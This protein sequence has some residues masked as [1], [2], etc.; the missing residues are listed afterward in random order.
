MPNV[1]CIEHPFIST[2]GAASMKKM[3]YPLIVGILV[4][5][6]GCATTPPQPRTFDQLG[7]FSTTPLNKQS[8]RVSFQAPQRMD[9][10]TAEEIT[11][12]KA[13]QT[14]VKQGF[15]FFK[16]QNDP[17]NRSQQPPRQAIIYNSPQYQP[18][19]FSRRYPGYWPDPFYNST[20]LVDIDPIQV[21]YTIECYRP[22]EAPK[23]AFDAR[24][25]LQSLGQKYGVSPTGDVLPPA[26]VTVTK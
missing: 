24:L 17:S 25:I 11:L 20:E 2:Q 19:G 9:W 13:A 26:T 3:L 4:G 16:V 14:T 6:T 23:D 15:S 18:Y 10:G 7:H 1:C 8:F 21:A 12:L 5:L 22:H